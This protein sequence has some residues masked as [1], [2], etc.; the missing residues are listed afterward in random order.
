[1]VGSVCYWLVGYAFAYGE[2]AGGFIGS[3]NFLLLESDTDFSA[4]F[5]QFVF[6]ATA[7]TVSEHHFVTI[8]F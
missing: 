6:S 1:M 2:T 7:A 8:S 4:W 3:T 5:F